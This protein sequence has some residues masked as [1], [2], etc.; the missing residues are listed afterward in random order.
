M[1][2]FKAHGSP[3]CL[4][5]RNS[6]VVSGLKG[7]GENFGPY[8]VPSTSGSRVFPSGHMGRRTPEGILLWPN[9][10]AQVWIVFFRWQNVDPLNF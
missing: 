6:R 3:F 9:T 5:A 10:G 2:I 4:L 8:L 7:Q 1:D